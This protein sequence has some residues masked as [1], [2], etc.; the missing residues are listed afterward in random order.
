MNLFFSFIVATFVTMVLIPPLVRL[1]NRWHVVDMPAARKVH[2]TPVPR[3]GGL[4]MIIGAILPPLMWTAMDS[5][6]VG[7]LC[8][9]V[10]I[11]FFGAWDDIK[12]LDFRLKFLGQIIAVLTVVLYG[13]VVITIPPVFWA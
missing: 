1:A 12:G 13:G 9:I 7:F 10:V 2:K 4:A 5:Q 11:L 6:V 8:G 3:L